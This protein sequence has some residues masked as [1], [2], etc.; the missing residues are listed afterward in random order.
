MNSFKMKNV[1]LRA[2]KAKGNSEALKAHSWKECEKQ[3]NIDSIRGQ[4][5]AQEVKARAATPREP[6]PMAWVWSPGPMW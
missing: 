6:H 2:V 5:D 1:V 3:L 4:Q